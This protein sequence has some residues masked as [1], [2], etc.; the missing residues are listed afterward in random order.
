M[1]IYQVQYVATKDKKNNQIEQIINEC[2]EADNFEI[3]A[4]HA[5]RFC[6][7]YEHDLQMVRYLCHVTAKI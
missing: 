7:E 4:K 3:A 5:I 1:P 6:Q 2:I